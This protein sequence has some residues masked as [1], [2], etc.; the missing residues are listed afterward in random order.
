MFTWHAW[1]AMRTEL[2]RFNGAVE[3][4]PAIDAWMKQHAGEIGAIAHEWFNRCE[5]PGMKS[6]MASVRLTMVAFRALRNAG[7]LVRKQLL[8]ALVYLVPFGIDSP[9]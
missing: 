2:L 5:N 4:D 6:G 8:P 9:C 1:S 3:R 7:L